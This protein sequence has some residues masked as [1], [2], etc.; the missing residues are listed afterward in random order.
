[1]KAAAALCHSKGDIV[2]IADGSQSVPHIKV[3]VQDLGV[4]FLAF[5]GHKMLAPM[6]IGVL[7]GKKKLARRHAPLPLRRRD[8]P[9]RQPRGC[10]VR[11]GPP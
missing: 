9:V 6:G 3:D 10:G 8:D 2:V 1:M 4:D 11:R 5:S 7:W